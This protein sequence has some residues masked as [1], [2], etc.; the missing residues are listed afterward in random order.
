[1]K[2]EAHDNYWKFWATR[3]LRGY[4]VMAVSCLILLPVGMYFVVPFIGWLTA[5]IPYA[6]PSH[7]TI[8]KSIRYGITVTVWVGTV[9]WLAEFLPWLIRLIRSKK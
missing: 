3:L 1:M 2:L 9:S 7:E 6:L 8:V 5:N 4:F